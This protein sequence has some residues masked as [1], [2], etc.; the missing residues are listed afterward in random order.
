[1]IPFSV[2][3][4]PADRKI[5]ENFNS[6]WKFYKGEVP[7]GQSNLHLT[8][9]AGVLLTCLT[10]GASRALSARKFK[11][12]G[13]PSRGAGM[14]QKNISRFRKMK[15]EE[16]FSYNLTESTTTVKSG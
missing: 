2:I 6:G 4:G 14:V 12:Y 10:T 1:M 15:K 3:R 8:I 11:L 13:I 9:Q 7:D 5:I 16:K